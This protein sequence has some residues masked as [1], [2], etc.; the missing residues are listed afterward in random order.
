MQSTPSYDGGMLDDPSSLLTYHARHGLS[1]GS[2]LISALSEEDKAELAN[3]LT[4]SGWRSHSATLQRVLAKALGH[5][6][7]MISASQLDADGEEGLESGSAMLWDSAT[8]HDHNAQLYDSEATPHQRPQPAAQDW[9]LTP[10]DIAVV[11]QL[12]HEPRTM[13]SAADSKREVQA[14]CAARTT[15]RP[16]SSECLHA[17]PTAHTPSHIMALPGRRPQVK[18]LPYFEEEWDIPEKDLWANVHRMQ[19]MQSSASAIFTSAQLP[20]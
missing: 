13:Q 18:A 3:E 8:E 11:E 10:Q 17:T 14:V 20:S 1:Q 12:W 9:S 16:C 15:L 6:Q 2:A 19:R 5:R 7:S 4:V